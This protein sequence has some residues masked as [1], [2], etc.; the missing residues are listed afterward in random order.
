V[1]RRDVIVGAVLVMV[2]ARF[3]AGDAQQRLKMLA[4]FSPP[5]HLVTLFST[6][7]ALGWVEG[8][9]MHIE[10]FDPPRDIDARR[11]VAHAIL[12]RSPDII[13]V[14]SSA[15]L[16]ALQPETSAVPIVFVGI[17]D[18]VNQGFVESFA[19]PG[20]KIT[21]FTTYEP[22]MSGKWIQLLKEVAPRT[23]RIAVIYDPETSS[24]E[25]F[26][27]GLRVSADALGVEITVVR[28]HGGRGAI[29]QAV[30]GEGA[31]EQAVRS[32]AQAGDAGLVF[33]P[34]SYGVSTN[35]GIVQIAAQYRVPAVYGFGEFVQRGGL[36]S[37]GV[38]LSAQY[39]EAATYIDRILKGTPPADLPVQMP[40]KFELAI[41]LRT[42]K[43]LG[44]VIPP[45]LLAL[46][47]EVIE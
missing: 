32:I 36:I 7:Q 13:F 46:A 26:L 38:N 23:R 39:S 37:Y 31:I 5:F 40:T 22:S 11:A 3:V 34:D 16:S 42:A 9:N 30:R 8:H 35:W 6:L 1:K 14:D 44:I 4:V 28:V 17:P 27:P 47:D 29:E 2:S 21:G 10:F 45:S 43:A 33:P 41:N 15:A 25:L 20:G 18:P 24:N 19:K 12:A